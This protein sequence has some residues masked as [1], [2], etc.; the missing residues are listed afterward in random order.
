MRGRVQADAPLGAV[1]LVPRRRAGGMRWCGRPMPPTWRR[2]CAALPP[3]MPVT[4]HRRRLQPHHPRWRRCPAWCCG[5]ARGFG[6]SRSSRRHR[7][8]RRGA[9]RD[10]RRACR[11][12]RAG[13]ARIPLRHPRQHRRRGGDECRRL[14]RRGG[15][16]ARLGRGGDAPASMRPPGRRRPRLRLSPRRA[17]AAARRRPRPLPRAARR[18]RRRS[19]RAWPRSARRARR[20]QPVRARTGGSTFRNPPGHEGLGA[21]RRRRLPRPDA[22]RRAGV[23]RSTATSCSTPAAPPPPTSKALGEEVRAPRAG[24]RAASTLEWEIQRIGVQ[25]PSRRQA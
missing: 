2:C 13:R 14:W 11:R 8:R 3:A 24:A 17:A 16:R 10:G 20:R 18:R 12:R 5:S 7:R 22:R 9:R 4:V 23:A 1:H 6:A 21:D 19:P 15:G 25:R